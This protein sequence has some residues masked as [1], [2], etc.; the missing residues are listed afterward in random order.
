MS[1]KQESKAKRQGAIKQASRKAIHD[2]PSSASCDAKAISCEERIYG[3]EPFVP[4]GAKVLILGSMPSVKSLEQGFYYMPSVKSLEQGFYYAHPQNRMFKLIA[5]YLALYNHSSVEKTV[6]LV[7]VSERKDALT[8][9]GIAMWDTVDSCVRNGSLDSNI[10]VATYADIASLL[11]KHGSIRCVI[12]AGGFAA[13]AF[14]KST[15]SLEEVKTGK[16]VFDYHALP[17]TSPANTVSFRC[18]ITAGG[19]AAKAFKKSTLSLEEVKT[20][21]LVFDYHALPS[22]SPANTVSFEKLCE[23]STLSLEEVKTGKLVFDYHALPSTSPA[24]TVSFEKLCESYDAV[25]LPHLG[26]KVG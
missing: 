10:K 2:G 5:R 20:G 6:P 14:K 7:S 25:I 16:L 9:L 12:T 19:F 23:K 17:S 3:F 11:K 8:T 26:I 4:E 22:T 18:V 21:K 15:L 1:S 24:N 13:K